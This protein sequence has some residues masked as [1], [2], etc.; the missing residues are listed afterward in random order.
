MIIFWKATAIVVITVILSTAIGKTEKDLSLVLTAVACC[1]VSI[2]ALQIFSDVVS[3]L[4]KLCNA[5]EIRMPFVGT[6]LK[7][8]GVAFVSELVELISM[9]SGSSSL[10]K[11]MDFL[12]KAVMLSLSLPMFESFFEIVLEILNI[13]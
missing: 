4:W 13:I 5:S 10:C 6:L 11:A 7:I 12:G 8:A 1:V 9:D 2:L 3:F